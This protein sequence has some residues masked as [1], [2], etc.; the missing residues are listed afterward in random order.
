MEFI[1]AIEGPALV[2]RI[3]AADAQL[4]AP[5][6]ESGKNDQAKDLE[7]W[8]KPELFVYLVYK[9]G[10]IVFERQTDSLTCQI[11]LYLSNS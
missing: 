2:S 4:K 3:C 1:G 8:R 11:D 6:M 10:L 5:A 9:L 7:K